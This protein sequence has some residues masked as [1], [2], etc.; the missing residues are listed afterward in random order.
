MSFFDEPSPFLH[1]CPEIKNESDQ[2]QQQINALLAQVTSPSNSSSSPSNNNNP[3]ALLA[4]VPFSR[5]LYA[6]DAS[7]DDLLQA[8][9]GPSI[10]KGKIQH[11][12][13]NDAQIEVNRRRAESS[14][15]LA[16]MCQERGH[17]LLRSHIKASA[18][19]SESY[20]GMNIKSVLSGKIL[21]TFN[22]CPKVPV[23]AAAFYLRDCA[24]HS[25]L[26]DIPSRPL[27]RGSSPTDHVNCPSF[28]MD[29]VYTFCDT[30]KNLELSRLSRTPD[31]GIWCLRRH[32]SDIAYI[33]DTPANIFQSADVTGEWPSSSAFSVVVSSFYA[34]Q[35]VKA[36]LKSDELWRSVFSIVIL[37]EN[38]L[39]END[40][41]LDNT[42]F[43]PRSF[44]PYIKKLAIVG[45]FNTPFHRDQLPCTLTELVLGHSYNLPL[46]VDNLPHGLTALKVGHSY[47]HPLPVGFG[48]SLTTMSIGNSFNHSFNQLNLSRKMETLAVGDAWSKNFDH[49]VLGPY[50]TTLF[51]GNAF[52]GPLLRGSLPR[53]LRILGVGA[54]MACP[55]KSEVLPHGLRY[56][57]VKCAAF[58]P[59]YLS[60]VAPLTLTYLHI[61]GTCL[62]RAWQVDKEARFRKYYTNK[63]LKQELNDNG[64]NHEVS[65]TAT[66]S[67]SHTFDPFSFLVEADTLA[68]P[69]LP[70]SPLPGLSSDSPPSSPHNRVGEVAFPMS[71]VSSL[72]PICTKRKFDD[73]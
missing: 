22:E 44:P 23:D 58:Q 4:D 26:D 62:S 12:H 53:S 11:D 36:F 50:V 71:P 35:F 56:L 28:Y 38:G 25:S 55:V 17:S 60:S 51:L 70:L 47:N 13:H 27:Y 65:I 61:G 21:A 32:G 43:L 1:S 30:I 31:S 24:V 63:F 67:P 73:I 69:S 57:S 59:A 15:L 64:Q 46:R 16:K 19:I 18:T 40:V 49:D 66:T 2:L 9:D 34:L 29:N 54:S 14:K 3:S 37:R 33:M 52:T 5:A 41:A 42:Y 68:P 48:P 10:K 7:F 45:S 72:S 20:T 6:D 39:S 8:D